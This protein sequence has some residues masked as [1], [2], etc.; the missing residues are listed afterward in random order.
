MKTVDDFLPEN[1][2]QQAEKAAESAQA[3]LDRHADVLGKDVQN[4]RERV[5]RVVASERQDSISDYRAKRE[6]GHANDN[7]CDKPG[8]VVYIINEEFRNLIERKWKTEKGYDIGDIEDLGNGLFRFELPQGIFSM[9]MG[10]VQFYVKQADKKEQPFSASYDDILRI[11]GI[12]HP[13]L[14]QNISYKWDGSS[15]R[16]K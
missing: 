7:F 15:K 12:G 6:A 16:A 9:G 4:F 14:W 13:T 1:V 11:E 2:V 3:F 10:A 5:D 8:I